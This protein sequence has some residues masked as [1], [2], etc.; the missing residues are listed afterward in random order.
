[1]VLE[2]TEP[3][4]PTRSRNIQ[5]L[6]TPR[7]IAVVGGSAAAEV[8]RQCR[9]VGYT[10]RI[11]PVNPNR[12]QIEGVPCYPDV[13]ALPEAP[14]AGFIGVPA[15]ATV[16][17]VAELARRGA[18]GVVCH[19]SGFAEEG[20]AGRARQQELED[21]AGDLAVVGPN[22][23]G[24]LNYLDGVALWPDQHG[25]QRVDRGVAI[26]S[27][28]GNIGQNLTMR[29]RSLPVAC[30]ATVGNEVG[31]GVSDLVDQLADDPRITAIGLYLE[32]IGDVAALAG[33]ATRAARRGVPLVAVKSGSSELGARANLSHTSSL[34]TPD[35]LC[36]ALFDRVGIARVDD[37]DTF[38]ETL[39]FLHT[40]GALAGARIG[41][42]SCS[43]GEAALLADLAGPRGVEF[44]PFGDTVREQLYAVLG[45]R[46]AIANPLDYHTYIWGD[47]DAQTA[48]FTRFLGSGFDNHVLVLDMPRAEECDRQ[49]WE[50]TAAAFIAA[51]RAAGAPATVVSTSPEGMPEELA[52]R[53][54]GAGIAALRGMT[55]CVEAIGAAARIGA[56]HAELRRTEADG[57]DILPGGRSVDRAA[58]RRLDEPASKAELREAGVP[59]PDGRLV[60]PADAPAA[61]R[62]LGFPVVLK[63]V[64]A[65]LAHKTEVGGVRL[66]LTTPEQVRTAAEELSALSG[67]LLVEPMTT[68]ALAELIVGVSMDERFGPALTLGSGGVLVELVRDSVTLLLPV[69]STR[70]RAALARLRVARLLDGHRG[71]PAGDVDAAVDAVTAIADY[72]TR[73]AHRLVDLDV[74]PLLV[75]PSGRG[76]RAVDAVLTF[77]DQEGR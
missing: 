8:I 38:A 41:S 1:M 73:H 67:R 43:G 19:A 68:D 45:D 31:T 46:V 53:F 20:D 12:S 59:V 29:R 50:T 64:S 39:Q 66:N 5:R 17:V 15:P 51:R 55:A 3:D 61:A 63:A 9:R 23:I 71:G 14:D 4:K 58:L 52:N 21:A 33:A 70:V 72:A 44:P 35:A 25:G 11:W 10:G 32:G 24:L 60:P 57:G 69:D 22:C 77:D 28:S 30:L 49:H 27:Q 36:S 16:R 48:C 75:R 7:H 65:D 34:A 62:E 37:L 76:V 42:A 2:V 56:A 18:G 47:L 6:L 40:H 26:L 54:A 13:G 74:N